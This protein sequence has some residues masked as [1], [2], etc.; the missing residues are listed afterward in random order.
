MLLKPKS[1]F[2]LRI[3]SSEILRRRQAKKIINQNQVVFQEFNLDFFLEQ[4]IE[5]NLKSNVNISKLKYIN[6]GDE[7]QLNNIQIFSGPINIMQNK[8][9]VPFLEFSI[10]NE[11]LT[12]SVQDFLNTS[13][14]DIN[15]VLNN[16]N[17]ISS[18]ITDEA[19]LATYYGK[20][21]DL[22]K[23]D[24]LYQSLE[25]FDENI[26]SLK[27]IPA[28][29]SRMILKLKLKNRET[30]VLLSSLGEGINRYIAILCAIWA[31]KD[32]YLFIDEIENAIHYTNYEKLWRIILEASE[33]ANCQIFITT[34]SKE[35]IEAFN[36]VNENDEG[37]YLE[38]YKNQK[39]GLI[40]VKERDNEQLEYAL[41]HNSEIRG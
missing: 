32:G 13:I 35:C 7:I 2:G 40:V 36:R 4:N 12:T 11:S 14:E 24:Y 6:T 20:L 25:N 38:F 22:N 39:N 19:T 31:S 28:Q 8:A 41:S 30:P 15:H 1:A 26:V 10:L 34:H 5:I 3:V 27:A 23:E 37:I 18:C 17:F 33:K 9:P 29:H 16:V 21:M